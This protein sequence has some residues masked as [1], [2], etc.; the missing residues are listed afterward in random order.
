MPEIDREKF[1]YHV[2]GKLES[3]QLTYDRAQ[4][5]YPGIKK[6]LLTKIKQGHVVSAA[7]MLTVCKHLDLDP[8]EYLDLNARNAH[9]RYGA[10][11]KEKSVLKQPVSD[12]VSRGAGSVS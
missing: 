3:R 5:I 7:N 1:S 12:G 8:L 4:R 10:P 2:M 6:G 9:S 11:Y